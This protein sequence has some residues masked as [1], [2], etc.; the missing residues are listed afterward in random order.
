MFAPWIGTSFFSLS[1]WL[2]PSPR[3]FWMCSST[4]YPTGSPIPGSSLGLVL[5]GVFF[6]WKGLGSAVAGFLL[7]GGIMFVFYTVR[8]M[9]AGDVK[10]MAAIGSLVGPS[11]AI[12]VLLATAICGGVLAIVYAIYRRRM[13]RR[14]EMLARFAVSCLGRS[15]GPS[16]I[17][18][19]QSLGLAY[20][21]WLGNCGGNSVRIFGTCVEVS[22]EN[23]SARYRSIVA[24]VV[25]IAVT[26][27]SIAASSGNMRGRSSSRL[28]SLPRRWTPG[29]R[30]G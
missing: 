21:V 16:G 26:Y 20:A 12:V 23:R 24:L 4:A 1:R 3:P 10:L 29:R 2:W 19:G 27:L 11:H 22:Y 30:C 8:A 7:A 15:A 9:G 25:S 14:S 6:G 13:G 5:R 17:E 28:W 18:S